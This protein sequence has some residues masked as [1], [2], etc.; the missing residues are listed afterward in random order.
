M[1]KNIQINWWLFMAS[2]FSALTV[3]IVKY[4]VKYGH[5]GLLL[6]AMISE[7]GLIYGYIWILQNKDILTEFALVKILSILFV[8][9]PSIMF[10]GS[11][12]TVKTVL[13]LIAAVV[14][15]YLLIHF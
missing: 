15:I 2:F 13:G 8:I 11:E 3:V 9:I 1:F 6:L 14:A 12:L 7:A 5:K 4:Y 10:F